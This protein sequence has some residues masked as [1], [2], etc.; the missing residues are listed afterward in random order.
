MVLKLTKDDQA[1]KCLPPI[2][3]RIQNFAWTKLCNTHVCR[4]RCSPLRLIEGTFSGDRWRLF[5]IS[6]S[7]FHQD[8]WLFSLTSNCYFDLSRCYFVFQ[9]RRRQLVTIPIEIS[10]ICTNA[11]SLKLTIEGQILLVWH[12]FLSTIVS[13]TGSILQNFSGYQGPLLIHLYEK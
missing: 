5:W 13:T 10:F 1:K 4:K 3:Y 8:W 11:F 2:L 7:S 12:T 6:K 9:P